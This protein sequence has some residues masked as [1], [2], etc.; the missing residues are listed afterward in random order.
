M[1]V[2][3]IDP[4]SNATGYAFLKKESEKIEVLEYGVI[5]TKPTDPLSNKLKKIYDSLFQLFKNYQP[6]YLAL[7][8][9]FVA[10]YPGAALVLGH[11]RGAI[12]IAAQAY[13][14][15]IEEYEPRVV[16]KAVVGVGRASKDQIA[17]MIQRHLLLQQP[18]KPADAADALAV[19]Y[20]HLLR[21]GN[22]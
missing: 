5:R 18:P 7:E 14:I 17:A 22:L 1:I 15:Q 2:S 13:N 19:A 8:T 6:K 11:T 9:A 21:T 20:C 10:K 16:K 3:G 4:G 12:M